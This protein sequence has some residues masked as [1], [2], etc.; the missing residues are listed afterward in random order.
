MTISLM[1]K[2]EFAGK[3]GDS[4]FPRRREYGVAGSCLNP[5]SAVFNSPPCLNPV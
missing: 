5:L 1:N 4:S 3:Y 2:E